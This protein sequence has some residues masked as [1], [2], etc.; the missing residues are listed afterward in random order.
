MYF[1]IITAF[2]NNR[3][4]Q[5]MSF[6]D[7][8]KDGLQID[9]VFAITRMFSIVCR[10]YYWYVNKLSYKTSDEVVESKL[11][12]VSTGK[13]LLISRLFLDIH[14]YLSTEQKAQNWFN[15]H[16]RTLDD[17][18]WR[19]PSNVDNFSIGGSTF[20]AIHDQMISPQKNRHQ[21]LWKS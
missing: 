8:I 19:I 6:E 21:L 12:K 17:K 14:K 16:S 2:I 4:P 11:N 1:S 18:S 13:S 15:K 3:V 7:I 20:T 5:S 9:V 10:Q